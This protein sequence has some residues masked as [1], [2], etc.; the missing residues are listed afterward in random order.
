MLLNN[1]HKALF[2]APPFMTFFSLQQHYPDILFLHRGA[3][4][5]VNIILQISIPHAKLQVRHKPLVFHQIQGIEYIV[6]LILCQNQTIP[7]QLCQIHARRHI[8]ERICRK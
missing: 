5:I 2:L 3:Q 4:P 8:V 7:H 6:S 1:L